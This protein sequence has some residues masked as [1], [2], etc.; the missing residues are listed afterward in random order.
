MDATKK[1]FLNRT[2]TQFLFAFL[3]TGVALFFLLN[4]WRRSSTTVSSSSYEGFGG[5][6]KGTGIP[7]C[8]RD[9]QNASDLYTIF[10]NQTPVSEEGPDDL[11]EFTLLLSKTCCLK[12]DILSP[13]GIVE[14]TRYQPY[15]TAH[16][17]EPVAETAA[18][19]MA[20]TI[21]ERDLDIG[22]EKWN[23]R[24]KELLRSLCTSYK[25]NDSDL[26]KVDSKFKAHMDDITDVAKSMCL[27]GDVEIAG[28]KSSREIS[29][30]EPPE[31][32][33]LR[34]YKGYY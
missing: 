6:A 5:A 33:E 31:L 17:I 18:R 26:S 29:G 20:K 30:Y 1:N 10:S 8:L 34:K 2:I 16:D 19:C 21:P 11:R 4:V 22:L 13:S 15:S 28:K 7:D 23:R 3:V 32:S 27:K 14:A 25:V 24:G 9:S 12:K